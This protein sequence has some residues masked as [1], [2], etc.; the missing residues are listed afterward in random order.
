MKLFQVGDWVLH[1]RYRS[2]DRKQ[3]ARG[4]GMTPFQYW[5]RTWKVRRYYRKNIRKVFGI[6][7]WTSLKW[8]LK[9]WISK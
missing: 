3:L 5:W 8:G 2:D 9:R 6:S 4:F 7:R 1:L